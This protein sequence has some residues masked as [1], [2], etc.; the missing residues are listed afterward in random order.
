MRWKT[1]QAGQ[2]IAQIDPYGEKYK[3]TTKIEMGVRAHCFPLSLILVTFSHVFSMKL[4]ELIKFH[5]VLDGL[6]ATPTPSQSDCVW[7]RG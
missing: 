6:S 5:T 7:K 3:M 1:P 2:S 4:M